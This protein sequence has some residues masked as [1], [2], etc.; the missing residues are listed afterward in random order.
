M[1]GDKGI[2]CRFCGDQTLLEE[3]FSKKSV[4]WKAAFA[5]KP[6]PTVGMGVFSWKWVGCQAAF[7]SKPAPT[8]GLSAFS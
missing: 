6:A 3:Y 4:H 8:F 1:E 5:G 2:G 7:A